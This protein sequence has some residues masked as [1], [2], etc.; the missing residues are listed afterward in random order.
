[1]DHAGAVVQFVTHSRDITER[2][3]TKDAL[4]EAYGYLRQHIDNT[5]LSVIE[6]N[7]EQ[8]ILQWSGQA[9]HLFGWSKEEVDGRHLDAI[10]VV[11]ADDRSLMEEAVADLLASQTGRKVIHLRIITKDGALRYCTWYCSVVGAG[12]EEADQTILA[13]IEDDTRRTKAENR[14]RWSLREKEV[15][16]KEVHHRVKNNL[17]LMSSIL[18]LQAQCVTDEERTDVLQN[19]QN[20]IRSMALIHEKLFKTEDVAH[21]NFEDYVRTL[22]RHLERSLN[23]RERVAIELDV[24]PVHLDVDQAVLGGLIVNELVSNTFQHAFPDQTGGTV[25]IQL[26]T[27]SGGCYRLTVS[28]DGVGLPE[29]I[30]AEQAGTLGLELVHLLTQQ[31]AGSLYIVRGQGTTFTIDFPRVPQST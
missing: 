18:D 27:S 5:P 8:G 26:K 16:L 17:Q 23:L 6:W 31:L 2:K 22:V 12:D 4:E 25:R 21:V 20:R 14:L 1:V 10:G 13:L 29:E 28:D 24:E 3:R 11:H 15:L 19:T 9:H 30:D 7:R